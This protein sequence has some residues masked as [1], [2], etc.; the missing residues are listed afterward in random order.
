MTLETETREMQP[1]AKERRSLQELGEAG[2]D[3]PLEPLEGE[4]CRQHLDFGLLAPRSERIISFVFC[5]SVWGN[6]LEQP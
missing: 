2:E 1:Q 3:P 6:V 4:E 5:H